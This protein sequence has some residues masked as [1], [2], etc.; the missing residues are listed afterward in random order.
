MTA[1]TANFDPLACRIGPR[2]VGGYIYTG[3]VRVF[4]AKAML[5][6]RFNM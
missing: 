3:G 1:T 6:Q 2:L 4:N 5:Q